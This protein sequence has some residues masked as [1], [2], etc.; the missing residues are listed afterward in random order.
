MTNTEGGVENP[1]VVLYDP[2]GFVIVEF[3][4]AKPEN[5]FKDTPA[6]ADI[7][8]ELQTLINNS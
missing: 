5:V 2:E 8:Y 7:Y 1:S 4:A 3:S 6:L